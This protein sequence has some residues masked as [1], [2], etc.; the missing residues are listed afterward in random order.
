MEPYKVP[1]KVECMRKL[2]ALYSRFQVEFAGSCDEAREVALNILH[3]MFSA[4]G[5]YTP[6]NWL[7]PQSLGLLQ[8]ADLDNARKKLF[9]KLPQDLSKDCV[10]HRVLSLGGHPQRLRSVLL[11]GLR[12]KYEGTATR[13]PRKGLLEKRPRL[14][15]SHHASNAI[16]TTIGTMRVAV[17][18]FGSERES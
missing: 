5:T 8:I 9:A 4:S 10:T 14:P 3:Q 15:S 12:A 11:E 16:G 13:P 17:G 2:N 18:T 6:L 1:A 7:S